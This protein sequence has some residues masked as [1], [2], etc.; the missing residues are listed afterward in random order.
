MA[1]TPDTPKK[2][3]YKPAQ[4]PYNKND[5][6]SDPKDLYRHGNLKL[7]AQSPLWG[8]MVGALFGAVTL[9]IYIFILM[10][11]PLFAW[12]FYGYV[13]MGSYWLTCIVVGAAISFIYSLV[14]VNLQKD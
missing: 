12:P 9:I 8:V 7:V 6:F 13:A 2:Y 14:S 5:I 3:E 11:I 4:R 10:P 1:N